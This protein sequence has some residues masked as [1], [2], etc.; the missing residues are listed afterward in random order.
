MQTIAEMLQGEKAESEVTFSIY[1]LG[2]DYCLDS[3]EAAKKE[4]W[5]EL[6]QD[7]WLNL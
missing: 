4:N 6:T 2:Y 5:K 1:C 7:M 3:K